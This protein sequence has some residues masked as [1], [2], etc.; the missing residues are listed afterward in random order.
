MK[1]KVSRLLLE[2]ASEE[3]VEILNPESFIR[4]LLPIPASSLSRIEEKL[5][6]LH[7]DVKKGFQELLTEIRKTHTEG[8]SEVELKVV[9]L[10]D[11]K[12]LVL[13]YVKEHPG[14]YTSDIIL[15][16]KLDPDLVLKALEELEKDGKIA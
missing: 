10:E 9:P 13:R 14:C 3:G 4:S 2:R 7:E 8:S 6:E 5:G 15:D 16:L 1:R 11:A 12:K